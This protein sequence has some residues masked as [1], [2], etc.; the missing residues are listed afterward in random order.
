MS[1]KLQQMMEQL[2]KEEAEEKRLSMRIKSTQF[3][4][5]VMQQSDDK[6]DIG[7]ELETELESHVNPMRSGVASAALGKDKGLAGEIRDS[8][9]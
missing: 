7:S 2:R 3:A 5:I 1:C 8:E 9:L 4:Q 6:G